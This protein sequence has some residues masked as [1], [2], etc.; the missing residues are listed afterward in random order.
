MANP[1]PY[2]FTITKDVRITAVVGIKKIHV[3]IAPAEH[4][5]ITVTCGEREYTESFIADY[6]T[7]FTATISADEGYLPGTLTVTEGTFTEDI[8]ISATTAVLNNFMITI[9]Q[10]EHQ[11]IK[12]TAGGTVYTESISLPNGTQYVISIE[13]EEG[14]T[15]G[16]LT[17]AAGTYTL[18][19]DVTIKATAAQRKNIVITLQQKEHETLSITVG[20]DTYQGNTITLLSGTKYTVTVVP[21]AWYT[22]GKIQI[23]DQQF[24]SP[25]TG[26]ATKDVTVTATDAAFIDEY[27]FTVG[28]AAQYGNDGSY[29]PYEKIGYQDYNGSKFGSIS[30]TGILDTFC[31]KYNGSS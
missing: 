31:V 25:Y 16:A 9:Q 10:S 28:I 5:T 3:T 11:T 20:N 17:P 8:T 1:N 29:Q 19:K 15:A 14:F 24:D 7:P 30:P 2:T 4:Q 13:P 6:G 23:G 21:D 26:T 22:A 27:T 12:V 18:T